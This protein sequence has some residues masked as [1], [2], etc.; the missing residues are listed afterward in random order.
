MKRGWAIGKV[1]DR[2]DRACFEVI[3]TIDQGLDPRLENGSSAHGTGFEGDVESAAGETPAVEVV[4]PIAQGQELGM[5]EGI[6]IAIATVL[7]VGDR[8]ALGIEEDGADGYIACGSGFLG[9]GQGLAHPM[10]VL[11]HWGGTRCNRVISQI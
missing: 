9:Q 2:S 7:G 8:L 10:L 4:G 6:T 5:A 3:G 1:E 11:V